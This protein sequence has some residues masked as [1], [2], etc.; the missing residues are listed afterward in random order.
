MPKGRAGVGLTVEVPFSVPMG[1]LP[2]WKRRFEEY[3]VAYSQTEQRFGESILPFR[4]PQGLPLAL[5]ETEDS[6]HFIPWDGSPVPI[7]AQV[8]GMHSV[9]L[10]ERQ[11]SPS[12]E[13]LADCLGFTLIGE[14]NGWHRYGVEGGGP[15]KMIEIKE[16]PG[17]PRDQWG[18]GSVHHVVWRVK[19]ADEQ[20]AV[21]EQLVQAGRQPT[22]QID[23]FW[24]K[25]VYFREPGGALFELATEGPGFSRDEQPEH[26]GERLI[27]PPWLEEQRSQIE[28]VLPPLELKQ[29]LIARESGNR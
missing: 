11:L 27:L 21:R 10:W 25:S 24:F 29:Q 4:D 7:D 14:E 18:T 20:T 16:L 13:M 22:Q 5:V 28:A 6:Q 23:R 26:L 12:A 19:D 9:R 3:H 8:R 2:Y 1:T 17:E 15:G